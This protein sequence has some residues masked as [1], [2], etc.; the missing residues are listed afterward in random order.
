MANPAVQQIIDAAT[1]AKS[2]DDS[3]LAYVSGVPKLINDAV[4]AALAKGATAEELAPLSTLATD[5]AASTAAV[6]K[7]ITDNTPVSAAMAKQ[8]K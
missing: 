4:A 6:Q 7:A 8:K 3:V 2:V 5:L 1:A